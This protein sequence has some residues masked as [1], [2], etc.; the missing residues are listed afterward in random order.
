MTDKLKNEIKSGK[1]MEFDDFEA[2]FDDFIENYLQNEHCKVFLSEIIC[3][4]FCILFRY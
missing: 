3:N 4:N 2:I 1:I